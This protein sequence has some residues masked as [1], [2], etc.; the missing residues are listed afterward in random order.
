MEFSRQEY[1]SWLPCPPP[2]G[3]PNPGI[4]PLSLMSLALADRIVI[5]SAT[6]HNSCNR[7][8]AVGGVAACFLGCSS[9]HPAH[10]S[11]FRSLVLSFSYKFLIHTLLWGE[12]GSS[13]ELSKS[14]G[15]C[16]WPPSFQATQGPCGPA[17]GG[18]GAVGRPRDR[19]PGGASLWLARAAGGGAASPSADEWSRSRG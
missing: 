5:A 3:L 18:V 16:F 13:P 14:G 2:G 1:W 19:G 7:S 11:L 10:T 6:D 9:A 17:D 15:H 4:K 12:G 8:R